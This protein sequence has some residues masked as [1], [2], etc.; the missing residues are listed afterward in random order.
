[1]KKIIDWVKSSNHYYHI[2]LLAALSLVMMSVGSFE[3]GA[4]GLWTNVWQT[5]K[6][7]ALVG[8]VIEVYQYFLAK[9]LNMKNTLGDLLADVVGIAMGVGV[10]SLLTLAPSEAAIM[11]MVS[12]FVSCIL[13]FAIPE[14]KWKLLGAFLG[15]MIVGF[16]LFMYA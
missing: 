6:F 7:G 8:V 12:S 13:A 1:M 3:F 11:L 14:H 4:D 2:G 9:V 5:V 16:S 15:C 10:Y